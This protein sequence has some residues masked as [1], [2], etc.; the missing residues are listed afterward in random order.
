M[1]RSLDRRG[2]LRSSTALGAGLLLTPGLWAQADKKDDINLALIGVGAQGDTL[3]NTCLKLGEDSGIR[4]K[5]VCDIYEKHT[6]K[7]VARVLQKYGHAVNAYVDY[8][9]LLAQEKDLDAVIIATPDF[10]HAKQTVAC[11]KAGLHVYCE[12]PMSN[13][14]EGAGAMVQAARAAGKHLQ[15]GFQRR[16]NPRYLHCWE[17]L[18]KGTRILGRITAVNAQWNQSARA[19][20]GWSRRREVPEETLAKYGYTSMQQFRNWMWYRK[21]GSGPLGFFGSHQLDAIS[22]FLDAKPKTVTAQGGTHYYDIKTHECYDTVMAVLEYETGQ[23]TVSALYQTINS[24]GYGKRHE[25]FMGDQGSMEMS[26][27]QVG[28]Y[29]D[30]EAPDWEKWVRLGFIREPGEPK[31]AA[32]ASSVL[33]VQ[34]RS[35]PPKSYQ[36]PVVMEDP[37]TMPHLV[38]F[39]AAIRGQA[40]LNCPADLAY[41]STAIVQKINAAVASRQCLNI[42]PEELKL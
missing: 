33:N 31:P 20:R 21:L 19:D 40:T 36:L 11:L 14:T 34:P 10:C 18:I 38:N 8:E 32:E 26:E 25:V 2:F 23:G 13:T 17:N 39:F 37:Y 22:W 9:D 7:R 42:S 30:A 1:D 24:N 3:M 12:A 5:A 15:I 4:F 28:L 16:S 41:A 29:R 27:G 6:L 35:Q